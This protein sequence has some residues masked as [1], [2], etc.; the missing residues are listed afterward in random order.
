MIDA[1]QRK[2][3]RWQEDGRIDP[4]H[5]QAWEEIFEKPMAEIRK[6]I[7]ADD[8]QGRDLRQNSPLAGL[9]SEPERRKILEKV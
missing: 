5:A 2:L 6:A 7:T 4:R 3:Q 8:Q 1:A 9:L